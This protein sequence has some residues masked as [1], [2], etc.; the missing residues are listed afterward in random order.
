MTVVVLLLD[1][2]ASKSA[3]EAAEAFF[4]LP[5]ATL[6][7]AAYGVVKL[8]VNDPCRLFVCPARWPLA[9]PVRGGPGVSV[10]GEGR[11]L[12]VVEVLVSSAVSVMER[13]NSSSFGSF[14]CCCVCT[15]TTGNDPICVPPLLLLAQTWP[16][17]ER[18]DLLPLP[19]DRG[20]GVLGHITWPLPCLCLT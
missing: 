7:N 9:I 20:E 12:F 6:L 17:N 10:D 5:E 8:A 4:P 19:N 1:C 16:L 2:C 3:A 11:V 15:L 14:S 18:F 13:C